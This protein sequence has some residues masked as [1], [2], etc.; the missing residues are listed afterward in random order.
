MKRFSI[1]L[2]L[3]AAAC[4]ETESD[5]GFQTFTG[6]R[7]NPVNQSIFEAI[8]RS[9]SSGSQFWC[10]AGEY[11]RRVLGARPGDK[12]YVVSEAGPAVTMSA[13]SAVQF[14]LKPAGQVQGAAGHRATWGPKI[15]DDEF[16]GDASRKC[17]RDPNRFTP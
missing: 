15:G 11:A 6:V 3:L 9:A 1:A 8:P 13:P 7:V 16:A 12:V 17:N 4:S 10:G 14:S 5:G 2:V